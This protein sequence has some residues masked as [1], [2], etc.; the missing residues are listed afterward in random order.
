MW[1]EIHRRFEA[2]LRRVAGT[3]RRRA[4]VFVSW[5]SMTFASGAPLVVRLRDDEPCSGVVRD[6]VIL[7]PP[8][9][10]P[11]ADAVLGFADDV[12]RFI[13]EHRDLLRSSIVSP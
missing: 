9:P 5:R 3:S 2:A 12:E 13:A 1:G 6:G 4:P 8:G 10:E 7:A 11:P